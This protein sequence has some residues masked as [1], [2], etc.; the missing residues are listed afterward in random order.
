MQAEGLRNMLSTADPDLIKYYLALEKNLFNTLAKCTADAVVGMQPKINIWTT[1]S[2]A[3]GAA[4]SM[5]PIRNLFTSL[6]PMLDAVQGQA[7]MKMPDWL[8][9]MPVEG[10]ASK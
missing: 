1:G 7:G 10:S 6:P 3:E 2:G 8:P 4:D 5:A 9:K